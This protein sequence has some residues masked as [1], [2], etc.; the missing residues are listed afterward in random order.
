MIP[1]G[2]EQ[3]LDRRRDR[4]IAIV[5]G[6]KERECDVFLSEEAS[7]KLRKVVLDQFNDFHALCSDLLASAADGAVIINEE[8][9]QRLDTLTATIEEMI[10]QDAS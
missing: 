3:L 4:A 1:P 7:R 6:V 2:T 10:H 5:L 9:L 8:Y